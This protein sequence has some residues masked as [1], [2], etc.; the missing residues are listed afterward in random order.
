[1]SDPDAAAFESD[2]LVPVRVTYLDETLGPTWLCFE[3]AVV[4]GIPA[5]G[6]LLHGEDGLERYWVEIGFTLVCP[7]CF[8]DRYGTMD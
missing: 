1:L 4:H 5:E 8:V 7:S 3:C 6:S 2:S